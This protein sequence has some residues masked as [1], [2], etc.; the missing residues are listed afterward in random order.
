M[1]VFSSAK[2][3]VTAILVCPDAANA[4]SATT[5]IAGILVTSFGV[6]AQLSRL[7]VRI[8]PVC[9]R[10]VEINHA[11]FLGRDWCA[12]RPKMK[13]PMQK[14]CARHFPYGEW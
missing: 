9:I 14:L 2:P 12:N 6:E 1:L 5:I 13:L 4:R 8:R 3:T 11:R 10:L 7:T